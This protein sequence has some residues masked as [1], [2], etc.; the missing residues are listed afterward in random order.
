[1][2][3]ISIPLLL[4]IDCVYHDDV[5]KRKY[6]PRYWPFAR[7]IHRWP[8]NSPRE[9]QWRGALMFPLICAWIHSWVNNWEA[10]DLGR[11]LSHY[12][13][14]VMIVS[15]QKTV[16]WTQWTLDPFIQVHGVVAGEK[17]SH[18]IHKV[19]RTTDGREMVES[20]FY[21]SARGIQKTA[22]AIKSIFSSSDPKPDNGLSPVRHHAIIWTIAGLLS[23]G[24]LGTEPSKIPTF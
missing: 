2:V 3:S 21:A 24:A 20:P 18:I 4:E 14:I 15:N 16:T 12:D 1:M 7:G 22:T 19:S 9:G 6:F 5:I 23:I 17:C 10:G 13:V 11:H 8:V